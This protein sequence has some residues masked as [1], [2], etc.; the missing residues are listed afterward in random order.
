MSPDQKLFTAKE[1]GKSN[2]RVDLSGGEVMINKKEHF[3]VM[4]M[5]SRALGK[6]NLGLSCSGAFIDDGD[7]R[8]LSALVG[9]VEMTM[10]THPDHKFLYRPPSY[11][12][13]AA[14]ASILLKHCGIKV[15]LQTVVTREH[16]RFSMLNELYR[17]IC[18]NGIDAW[19]IL[20][21]F[22]S[23]RGQRYPQLELSDSECREIVSHVRDLD[24]A[25]HDPGKPKCDIHYLLPGTEKESACRCV[26]KSVGI[27]PDGRVTACFWGLDT[28]GSLKDSKF[29]LGD[30][31][32]QSFEE[33]MSGGNAR[34]WQEY[35]GKCYLACA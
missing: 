18:D 28:Q 10:D 17:W 1:L 15:G 31:T 2:C 32:R 26:K 5:L 13:T 27:L 30:I 14:R 20:K 25:N 12:Q 16:R 29:L 24:M 6:E 22:P 3:P 8:R 11:H 4:E 21:F 23:G 34:F 33:I 35:R 7:A 9:D 19:S